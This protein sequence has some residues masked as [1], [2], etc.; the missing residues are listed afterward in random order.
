MAMAMAMVMAME[1]IMKRNKRNHV[2]EENTIQ[3]IQICN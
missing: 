2:R 1:M 3:K